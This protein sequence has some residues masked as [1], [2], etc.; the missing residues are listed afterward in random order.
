M[1]STLQPDIDLNLKIILAENLRHPNRV[2]LKESAHVL[3]DMLTAI[4]NGDSHLPSSIREGYYKDPSK[5]KPI[6]NK[7]KAHKDMQAMEEHLAD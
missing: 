3:N 5:K 7:L 1:E 6:E 4:D 2:E